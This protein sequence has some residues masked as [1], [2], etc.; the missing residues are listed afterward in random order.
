MEKMDN[1]VD[2]ILGMME[3]ILETAKVFPMSRGRVLVDQDQFL[4]MLADLRTQ[5][6]RELE[7]A[8]RIVAD[9]NNILET[10]KKEA[11]MTTRA[12]EERARR[13]VDHDEIVKQA[14]MQANEIMST[15]QLQ[16]RELKKAAIEYADS[17]LAQVDEQ[18]NKSVIEVRQR[19]QGFRNR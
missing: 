17:V 8:R 13:L 12:A 7:D 1:S 3:G 9:R 10:A 14:Q 2:S 5:L 15:A 18:L 11:E 6:P 4:E 16:S 19:R